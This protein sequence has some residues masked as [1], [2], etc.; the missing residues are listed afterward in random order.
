MPEADPKKKKTFSQL[1]LADATE[2]E[3]KPVVAR[4]A[5]PTGQSKLEARLRGA[6]SCKLTDMIINPQKKSSDSK[7]KKD[8]ATTQTLALPDSKEYNS[9]IESSDDDADAGMS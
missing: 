1:L 5:S 6:I 9:S 2:N 3:E 8:G 4:P 7:G